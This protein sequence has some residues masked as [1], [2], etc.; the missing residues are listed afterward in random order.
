MLLSR[1]KHNSTAAC[2]N[3]L[4]SAGVEIEGHNVFISFYGYFGEGQRFLFTY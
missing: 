3:R 1:V 4:Q 2:N